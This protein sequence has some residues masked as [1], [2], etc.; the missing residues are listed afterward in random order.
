MDCGS[1]AVAELDREVFGAERRQDHAS[2]LDSTKGTG[3]ESSFVLRRDGAVR[4]YCYA[5]ADGGFIAPMAAYEPADQLPLL[6][7]A[8]SWLSHHGVST[9]NIFVLSQNL[10]LMNALLDAG[11]RSQR[12]SF[13]L[14]SAPFAKFDRYHPAG[15]ALL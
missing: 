9:G 7:T 12:W 6:R 15:A 4:G 14:T 3:A 11:W 1:D 5:F 13:L 2:Y 8:A 10:T